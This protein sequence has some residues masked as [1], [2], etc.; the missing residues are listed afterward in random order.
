[1]ASV[2]ADTHA[3]VW[4]LDRDPRLS[5]T[6]RDAMRASVESGDPIYLASITLV[7][8][9]Y[10]VEKGRVPANAMKALR[11]ALQDLSFGFALVPLDLRVADKLREIPRTDVPD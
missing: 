7:E 2:A 10:L 1:M 9:T 3:A 11:E 8:L 4:F 6:A 5:S